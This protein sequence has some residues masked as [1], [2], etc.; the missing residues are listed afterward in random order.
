MKIRHFP[1][2]LALG[3]LAGCETTSIIN[4]DADMY[5]VKEATA[6]LKRGARIGLV[7]G[8]SQEAKTEIGSQAGNHFVLDLRQA[9]DTAIAMTSRHLQTMGVIA[10]ANAEKKMTLRVTNARTALQ[11][12]PFTFDSR[13][14]TSLNIAAECEGGQNTTAFAENA[15]VLAPMM[16]H[17]STVKRGVEGATMFAVT[18]LLNDPRVVDCINR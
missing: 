7:N 3:A 4:T 2:L 8:Y 17:E 13:F 16:S 5:S 18:K 14:R 15:A 6:P 1:F 10:D 9:T 12:K 11:L